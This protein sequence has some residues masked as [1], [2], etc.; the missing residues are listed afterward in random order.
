[1][2]DEIRETRMKKFLEFLGNILCG[3]AVIVGL[4]AG[5]IV[6]ALYSLFHRAFSPETI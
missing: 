6:L 5:G 1:M 3:I 2:K 4:V